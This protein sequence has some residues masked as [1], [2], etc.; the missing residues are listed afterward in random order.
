MIRDGVVSQDEAMANAD[1]PSNLIW[2]LNNTEAVPAAT[3]GVALQMPNEAKKD[4]H[5]ET[6]GASFTEITLITE[7]SN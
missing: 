4:E 6:G 2:L 3:P 5:T 7:D 1:S